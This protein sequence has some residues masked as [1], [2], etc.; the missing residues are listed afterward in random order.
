MLI[1]IKCRIQLKFQ[2]VPPIERQ[3][4][5]PK[6]YK[7][8]LE[9]K[10]WQDYWKENQTFAFDP[11]S[12]KEI[13]SIDTPPPTVSGVLHIGHVYSYTQAEIIARYQRMIGKNVFYPFGFDDNGLPTERFVEKKKKVR[14][15]KMKRSEFNALCRTTVVELEKQFQDMWTALGFSADWN[16]T[17]ATIQDDCQRISQR[18]F[19]D[20]HKKDLVEHR[21]E[22][23][24]WCV[25]CQTAI[26]QAELESVDKDSSFNDLKFQLEDDGE[27]VIG[28]TRPELLPSCVCIFVHPNDERYKAS[29][30][31]NAIVPIFGHSVPILTD[32]KADMEKGTGAVMCCT[33][34]DKTD[35][36]WFKKHKLPLRVSIS[37]YG[38]TTELAGDF[39]N[40]KIKEARKQ[41]IAKLTEDGTLLKSD[42]ISHPV[43][44]HERCGTDIEFL[45]TKQWVIKVMDHKED[46]LK[47]ADQINWYPKFMKQRYIHWVENLSW[48]WCISRQRFFGVPFPIWHCEDCGTQV[49]PDDSELP[50]DPKE[51]PSSKNCP[52]CDSSNL[53]GD[54]NIM[55]T[56]T[57]SSVTPQVNYKWGEENSLESKIAPMSMRPQA[58]DIIRTWAF[59]TIVKSWFHQK[60]I[61]WKDIMISGHVLYKK[62]EKISKK[63]G[64]APSGP[65]Q[66]IEKYSADVIRYWTAGAKLG[67][68][69]YFEEQE[70]KIAAKLVTKLFNASKFALMHLE[71]F[72]TPDTSKITFAIDKGLVSLLQKVCTKANHY[73]EQY[74]YSLAL[75]EIESFFWDFCDNYMELMKHRIYNPE[76]HGEGSKESAQN[77]LYTIIFSLIRLLAPF[78]PHITEEIYHAFFKDI[79]KVDSVHICEYPKGDDSFISEED[80]KVYSDSKTFVGAIRKFKT[81]NR[82]SLNTELDAIEYI[83]SQ[84][85][86]IEKGL[87]DVCRASGC[88]NL[89]AIESLSS[90]LSVIEFEDRTLGIDY[91]AK[92][93]ETN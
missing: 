11:N 24:M 87:N 83:S 39:Q 46:L 50:V 71:G 23:N 41:I 68:D 92:A 82:L 79:E 17:Y 48:D 37:K 78:I 9:E 81:E 28:T 8:Q 27:I 76:D 65:E 60:D 49:T 61:P 26:A 75:S 38:K 51:N 21:D 52:K 85:P 90:E 3:K 59:Y 25:E 55:D 31:K 47:I 5:L 1:S 13:Y 62:G 86:S 22:P 12:D 33:F 84:F 40:L 20:L 45:S 93:P 10:K 36:E 30:G 63:K 70:F 6:K 74:E 19:L 32:E 7:P 42:A 66:L 4:M 35:I 44:T 56:W 54:L 73:L 53:V 58:H 15:N 88:L 29:I 67:A 16:L 69:C 77:A 34:G 14:G 64:N 57:T 80:E 91:T 72:E 43:N 89:K 18:S 2:R